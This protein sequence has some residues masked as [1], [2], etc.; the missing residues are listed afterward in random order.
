[1]RGSKYMPR[2][3]VGAVRRKGGFVRGAGPVKGGGWKR[4][5]KRIRKKKEP[6]QGLLDALRR[7]KEKANAEAQ[8]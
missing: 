8:P 1:M 7:E 3:K 4:K 2:R 6:Y 5:K